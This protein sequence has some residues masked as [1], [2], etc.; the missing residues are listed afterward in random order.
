MVMYGL[1]SLEQP[2]AVH[3]RYQLALAGLLSAAAAA[4]TAAEA[5]DPVFTP[6]DRAVLSARGI[7]V[8]LLHQ[9]YA[10]RPL[11]AGIVAICCLPDNLHVPRSSRSPVDTL[12]L[13]PPALLRPPP[14]LPP[15]GDSAG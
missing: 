13:L 15:A 11:L 8:R 9:I 10:C 12:L 5:F 6:V 14:P 2:G 7:Q 3:I 4:A 1:G